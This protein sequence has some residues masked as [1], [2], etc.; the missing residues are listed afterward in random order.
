MSNK[1]KAWFKQLAA[2]PLRLALKNNPVRRRVIFELKQRHHADLGIAVP[3]EH[4]LACPIASMEHW[5]SYANIFCEK[6]YDALLAMIPLPQRWLDLGCHAG[7]FTLLLAMRHRGNQRPPPWSALLVD[8]DSR[9]EPAIRD[10]VKLNGFDA[11]RVCFLH[12]AIAGTGDEVAFLEKPYMTSEMAGDL[13]ACGGEVRTVRRL[14]PEEILRVLPPPYDLVK[15]DIEGAEE[16]FLKAYQPV[17]RKTRHLLF[18]WHSWHAGG[19][20]KAQ[21]LDMAGQMGFRLLG[22]QHMRRTV[23][24]NGK[25]ETAGIVL[26]E[27]KML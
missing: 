24:H 4:G 11:S 14:P 8:A 7:H 2:F 19:G 3:M 15:M 16:A 26:L 22:E 5:V 6:E 18:E 1:L 9:S 20:G 17:A 21:L 13:A 25:D 12:A 10:M 27:N 23:R